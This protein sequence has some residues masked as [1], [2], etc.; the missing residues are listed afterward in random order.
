MEIV[1][2][3][4]RPPEQHR[5]HEDIM[6][7]Q[8]TSSITVRVGGRELRTNYVEDLYNLT[9]GVPARFI[10]ASMR[11]AIMHEIENQLFQGYP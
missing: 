2:L 5:S 7:R 9:S 10:M 8:V 4:L 11:K 6:R 3:V 1:S